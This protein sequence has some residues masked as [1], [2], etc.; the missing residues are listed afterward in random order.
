MAE[1]QVESVEEGGVCIN[2]L[3]E[4]ILEYIFTMLSP[5][6]DLDAARLVSHRWLRVAG[7]AVALMRRAFERCDQF[8]WS[9]YEPD[10]HTGPFLAERCSH[11]A[12]YHAGKKAMFV[13]GGCT[14]TYTAFNDLWTFDLT[15]HTWSRVVVS[16]APFPSPK[17]LATLL[18]YGDDL[19][20]YGGF[21]KSSPNP[22]HQTSTFY[23][24]LHLYST[25]KNQWIEIV[26]ENSAPKLASHSASIVG[27]S[28]VVF[29]GS[30]GNCSSNEIWV[31]DIP[32]R[33]WLQ[34]H[35]AEG[36][37]PAARYGHSQVLLDSSHLLVVGGCGGPNMI[38]SDAWMLHFDISMSST[39]E[40]HE[41]KILNPEASAPQ[42][43][44][45]AAC[46]VGQHLVTLSRTLKKP[47]T[48]TDFRDMCIG[49]SPT[50]LNVRSALLTER[51]VAETVALRSGAVGANGRQ[52]G[53][54]QPSAPFRRRTLLTSKSLEEHIEQVRQAFDSEQ[55]VQRSS[56]DALDVSGGSV[57]RSVE[58]QRARSIPAIIVGEI[59]KL[60]VTSSEVYTTATSS[61]SRQSPP[62]THATL[63]SLVNKPNA[64]DMS[65]QSSSTKRS[66]RSVHQGASGSLQ[67]RSAPRPYGAPLSTTNR[68]GRSHD[69]LSPSGG[70]KYG[71]STK[72]GLIGRRLLS[73][74]VLDLSRVLSEHVARYVMAVIWEGEL[75]RYYRRLFLSFLF[76]WQEQ[77][78]E[79]NAP[80]DTILYSICVGRGEVIV[81]GGMRSDSAMEGLSPFTHSINNKAFV[82]R[83][84]YSV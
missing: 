27:D 63:S 48:R 56:T 13:F 29:G 30:M 7:N 62:L 64:D 33:V 47:K 50:P 3:P 81:F 5:Y 79:M 49:T 52:S 22:I 19:L 84:R 59:P 51:R 41:V 70:H 68:D 60:V 78:L 61:T 10:L 53:G 15:W 23:N 18:P 72:D 71:H 2:D 20:L 54:L 83:P 26:T 1:S 32:G 66:S 25:T 24:E 65:E 69:Q 38:Y 75:L 40:W 73:A 31:L 46:R 55:G 35:I 11:S 67:R 57:T 9:C 39:W 74:Y 16:R 44:C 43:W 45:H 28:M 12:C 80:E 76:R 82:L 8:E 58:L 4:F 77:D 14:A 42:L 36:R 17:A 34:P 37:R 21:S 6:D